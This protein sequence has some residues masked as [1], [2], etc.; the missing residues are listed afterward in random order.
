[1]ISASFIFPKDYK[2]HDQM[3]D[4]FDVYINST[5]YRVWLID[6][7]PFAPSTDPL[8]FTWPELLEMKEFEFRIVNSQEDVRERGHVRFEHNRLP[9]EIIDI[10]NGSSIAEFMDKFNDH[11]STSLQDD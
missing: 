9:R 3:I 8:L 1:M 5:T 6:F 11:I 4:I 10:S 2:T 7:N